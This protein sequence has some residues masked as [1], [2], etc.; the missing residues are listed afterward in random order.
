MN[1]STLY[2]IFA[3]FG[4]ETPEFTLL[5]ITPSVGIPQ[6]STLLPNISECPG[7]ILTY[8]TG[9]VGV[10][11]GIIIPIFVWQSPKGRCYGNQLNLG[12]VR[13][14]RL[15]DLYSLLRRWT[16]DWPIVNLFSND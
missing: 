6:K 12:D 2:T 15:E 14:H 4:P 1:F 13:R 11:V 9:L 8:F 3:T 10:L 5:T 16:T 7:P